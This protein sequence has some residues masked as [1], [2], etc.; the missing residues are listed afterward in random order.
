MEA[1]VADGS[2]RFKRTNEKR[3]ALLASVTDGEADE[4]SARLD[5]FGSWLESEGA[6]KETKEETKEA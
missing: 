5:N 6:S 2:E 1:Y 3:A 4:E